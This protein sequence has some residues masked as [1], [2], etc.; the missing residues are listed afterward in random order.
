MNLLLNYIANS[1]AT[2][3]EISVIQAK[4]SIERVLKRARKWLYPPRPAAISAPRKQE[5]ENGAK[6]EM[7]LAVRQHRITASQIRKGVG[8]MFFCRP[9]LPD[10]KYLHLSFYRALLAPCGS[11]R[12]RQRRSSTSSTKIDDTPRR[13]SMQQQ[14][15]R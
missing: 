9:L 6:P 2:S 11:T 12:T 8:N 14:G 7:A 1:N 13:F 4:I 10:K 3:C 5:E 15:K